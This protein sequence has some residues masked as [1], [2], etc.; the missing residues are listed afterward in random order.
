MHNIIVSNQYTASRV[1]TQRTRWAAASAFDESR[2][3]LNPYEGD[4]VTH[5]RTAR[6]TGASCVLSPIIAL[7]ALAVLL[8]GVFAIHSE[9]TGHA[10][11]GSMSASA[12]HHAGAAMD[13]TVID[14]A[15][16]AV[17]TLISATDDGL[18]NCA[19]LAMTCVLLLA[20]VAAVVFSRRPAA[21]RRLLAARGAAAAAAGVKWRASAL[22]AHCPG[23]T[24]L[25][26]SRV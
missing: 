21:R 22:P 11:H 1:P 5:K 19:L 26:I 18:L 25:C 14:M 15:G 6:T 24:L 7:L 9:A 4:V 2:V 13:I 20:L 8:V 10:M 12:T 23:L 17:V 16:P 3:S